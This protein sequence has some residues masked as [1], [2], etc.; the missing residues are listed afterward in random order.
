MVRFLAQETA[1]GVI[2]LLATAVALIWANLPGEIGH[3]YHQF[4][5]THL[6]LGVG[7]WTFLDESLEH[8]VSD[9]LMVLF[10]FVVGL[11]IKSELVTGDLREPRVAALPAIA[12]LGGMVVP[13]LLFTIVAGSEGG[14]GW[15][16]PMATDI[17]FAVGVLALLGPRVPH[18]L[19]LFLL[20]LAIVDDI[21][22]ILVIAVFYTT[23]ISFA[24][25]AVA[26]VL[27]GLVVALTRNRV[28]YTPLYA[29]IGIGIW[30]ATYQSGVHATIAGV[31]LGLLAPAIPLL[32]PRAFENVEDI[33]SGDS[34]EPSRVL[35]ANWKMK[36]TVSVTT[37]LTQV[38]SPWTSFIIV[39]LFA[40]ANAGIEL[41][42]GAVSTA[43][44]SRVTWGVILGLLVGKTIGVTAFTWL[45]VR[46][47]LASLPR[48]VT[49]QHV[50]GGGAVA[51][52]GFTV[53]L[54][55]A[56]LAFV[57]STGAT[58]ELLD[59]AIIGI[60]V[61]SVLATVTGLL[62]L[63]RVGSPEHEADPVVE[64]LH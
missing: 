8:V 13:A 33:F 28:W 41:S 11:E 38:L 47:N 19:K 37:R 10:F 26:A 29:V 64:P 23:S 2:L 17:A 45:A 16:V 32:G 63:R 42:G 48:G 51:G 39:P 36:E 52:I 4:W 27:L 57:D 58:T 35:D 5:E 44:T 20:T 21:G 46:F 49:I 24:W 54:F 56:N 25:L 15:G 18:Q 62:I 30:F 6:T 3:S 14:S 31:A 60:L 53:A 7:D 12:A 59:E 9:V 40:L 1:S 50:I 43:A 22:A 55:I 61:A 34:A